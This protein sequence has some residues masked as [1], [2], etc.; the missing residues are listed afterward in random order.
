LRTSQPVPNWEALR[1][2]F[3]VLQR[4]TYLN[5]CSYGA[6]ATPVRE[7]F[8][9]YLDS[10]D[11]KGSDWDWWVMQNENVRRVIAEFLNVDD[12]EVA[13]TASASAGINSLASALQF[14]GARNKIVISDFEFPT[15]GQIW[16]AQEPRGAKVVRVPS[17]RGYIPAERFADVV[18]E[19]TSL[20]AV[21]NVCFRNG[22]RLDIAAIAEIAR[23]KGSMILVDGYQALGALQFDARKLGIDFL[24]S[25]CLKYLLG[26][27]GIGFLYVR[28]PLIQSLKPTVTGWFAQADIGA[29]DHTRYDPSPTARRFESGTPPV[30]N[31]YAA[32]AGIGVLQSVGMEHVERRIASLVD[33]VI[34]RAQ[35]AGYR[36]ITPLE[37]ERHGP[38]VNIACSDANRMVALLDEANIVTSCRDNGLR[39]A[40]HFYNNSTDIERLFDELG[41]HQTLIERAS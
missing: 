40:P 21:T 10:R 16:Y 22:A 32:A 23:S 4:K 14:D 35:D 38:M 36:I 29:M 5:S 20:V 11:T 26:T 3:P 7:A 18:D 41:R 31:T 12:D 27:A 2:L 24:A 25:G 6:L 9:Q 28:Q 37:P 17:E 19:K 33:Q 39:V 15:N 13:V 1:A 30:P 34:A 8:Q